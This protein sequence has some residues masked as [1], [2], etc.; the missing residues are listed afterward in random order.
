MCMKLLLPVLQLKSVRPDVFDPA[1]V[2]Q[3]GFP[4][5]LPKASHGWGSLDA[6]N[7]SFSVFSRAKNKKQKTEYVDQKFENLTFFNFVTFQITYS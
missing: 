1:I 3:C 2:S 6:N 7:F 4:V 5:L